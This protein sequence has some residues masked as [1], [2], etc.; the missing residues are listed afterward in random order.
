M[1]RITSFACI[2][3]GSFL[4]ACL[5]LLD[6]DENCS[7]TDC[8]AVHHVL[9]AVS[10]FDYS[11][12]VPVIDSLPIPL[13]LRLFIP[14]LTLFVLVL[15]SIVVL[16]STQG[17]G[18]A[19]FDSS[20]VGFLTIILFETGLY[21]FDRTWWNMH[22]TNLSFYPFTLV[23]NK[24]VFSLVFVLFIVGLCYRAFYTTR[25]RFLF[26]KAMETA[27]SVR[28]LAHFSSER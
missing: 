5:I 1:A 21:F 3:L 7:V 8:A 20:Q 13:T 17:F 18:K 19:I 10:S 12:I 6:Y 28:R 11:Y 9:G 22:V 15:W 26:R 23:T 16:R 25:A 27:R 24:I 14:C 2:A 4:L